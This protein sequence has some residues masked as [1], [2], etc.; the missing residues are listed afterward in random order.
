M[1]LCAAR[2]S[3][4]LYHFPVREL[5]ERV[6]ETIRKRELIKA[7]DRVA[8]ALSG[9]A[10]SVALLRLLLGL[11]SEVGIV[12]S[13]AH[14]NHKLRGAE[15]DQDEHFVRELAL[16]HKLELLLRTA[17]VERAQG[18][19]IEAAARKLRYD[20]FLD[21]ARTGRANKISTGHT[22][23]DQAETVLLR[24]FRGTGIRGLAGILPRLTLEE[25]GRTCGEVVRPMLGLRREEI[26]EFLR[27]MGQ[28]WREDSSNQDPSFLRNKLRLR[29]LPALREAF[30]D[31]ALENLAD[32]A[33]I[34]R[35]EEEQRAA[36][37]GQW[38]DQPTLD[39]RRLLSPPLAAQRRLLRAWVESN[40]PEVSLSFRLIEDILELAKG[41]TGRKLEL[42]G[43]R[44]LRIA[45]GEL[46]WEGPRDVEGYEYAVTI[47]DAVEIGQLGVRIAAEIRKWDG[48]PESKRG[49]LL[50]PAK[51]KGK[52]RIRNWRAG[53][54]FWPANT[55]E[56]KKV[57]ELLSDRHAVGAEKKLWPVAE[58]AG[59]L[60]W[61]RG[62]DAPQ[63]LR[64]EAGAKRVLWIHEL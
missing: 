9:G 37:S 4:L 62:F 61:M 24:I 22:L 15:S 47:P 20:F 51:V 3:R 54:R 25:G 55:K 18:T 38:A 35:A 44:V 23:D 60:V 36:D 14:V 16:Q 32:L 30:G 11:R 46:H 57:K 7:G 1:C 10:D 64:P 59:E 56:P 52:L 13:V 27:A 58:A 5:R 33:E 2:R 8:V 42:R 63:A 39:L 41:T 28:A 31:S 12:L 6:L 40:A 17:P 26:R 50:D 34:A 43:G 29:V 48:V 21:L 49:Q 19:G 53:D 45:R